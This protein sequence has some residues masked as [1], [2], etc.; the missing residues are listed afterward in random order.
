MTHHL[1]TAHPAYHVYAMYEDQLHIAWSPAGRY[2]Q[3]P[4]EFQTHLPLLVR[5]MKRLPHGIITA[6]QVR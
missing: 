1:H 4:S 5:G 2:G 6:H 3:V